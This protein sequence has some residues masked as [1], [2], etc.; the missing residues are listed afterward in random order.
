MKKLMSEKLPT[1]LL[2][3]A[4]IRTAAQQGIAITII[5]KGDPSSGALLLEINRLD[6]TAEIL[7]QMWMDDERVWTS[8]GEPLPEK[9]AD[10]LAA[11]QASF[12]PDL[13]LIEIEDKKGRAWFPGKIVEDPSCF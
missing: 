7:T 6:G 13:W 10:A 8:H 11:E 2:V 5:R 1:H 4:Q 3:S 9:E 12:D